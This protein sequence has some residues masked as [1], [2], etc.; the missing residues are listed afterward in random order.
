MLDF[1]S[2]AFNKSHAVA[3]GLISYYCCYLKAHYPL[4]FAAATL[5]SQKNPSRQLALLRE[6]ALEGFKYVPFDLEKST[7]QWEV[8]KKSNILIGPL[9]NIKGIGPSMQNE[10]I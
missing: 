9:T 5:N 3:Y 2:Y 8:D 6:L 4:E 1:G 10:H 7:T